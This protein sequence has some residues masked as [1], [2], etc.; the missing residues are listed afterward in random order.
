MLNDTCTYQK[1]SYNR[2]IKILFNL[3]LIT[4]RTLPCDILAMLG[5]PPREDKGGGT[6]EP[7]VSD[8]GILVERELECAT[9]GGP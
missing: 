2:N 9:L 5:A 8:G 7:S 3:V 4:S 1:L 6:D